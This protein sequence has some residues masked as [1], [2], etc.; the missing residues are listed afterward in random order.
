MLVSPPPLAEVEGAALQRAPTLHDRDLV[1]VGLQDEHPAGRNQLAVRGESGHLGLTAVGRLGH[2]AFR[3]L[4]DEHVVLVV[5]PEVDD[6]VGEAVQVEVRGPQQ[7]EDPQVRR[8]A[9][10]R[11]GDQV[12]AQPVPLVVLVLQ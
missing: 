6:Q 1:R 7:R 12:L 10:D 9:R 3:V 5:Q 4:E 11:A 8:L 2:A